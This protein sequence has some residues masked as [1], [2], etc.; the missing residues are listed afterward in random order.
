METKVYEQNPNQ[1]MEITEDWTCLRQN[2]EAQESTVIS[3]M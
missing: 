1:G 2:P 3:N